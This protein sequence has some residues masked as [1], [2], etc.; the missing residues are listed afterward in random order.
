M[1]KNKIRLLSKGSVDVNPGKQPLYFRL[2]EEII[3]LDFNLFDDNIRNPLISGISPLLIIIL[4]HVDM[5]H[6]P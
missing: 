5:N 4:F 1:A 6:K 3:K 2:T